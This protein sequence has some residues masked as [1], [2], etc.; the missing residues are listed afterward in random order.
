MKKLKTI[1]IILGVLLAIFVVIG[2]V[3]STVYEDK[4]KSYILQQVNNSIATKVDVG[5]IEFSVFKKFPYASLEFKEITAE[6]VTKKEKKGELFKAQS[7]YLQFNIID[8]L[9]E[10]YIIKKIAIV[11]GMINVNIDKYGNDNYHFWKA[12]K[13]STNNSLALELERLTLKRVNFYVLNEYKKLD[14]DI[15]VVGATLSG[16]FSKEE[17]AL[18]TQANFMI[19]QINDNDEAILKNKNIVLNTILNVN[20]ITNIYQIKKG[21]IALEKL[22]FNLNGNIINKKTGVG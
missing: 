21:E 3:F 6:E 10:N 7:V 11:D 5:A 20:Q 18:N 13:D 17:F 2:V 16:N 14:M 15:E 9:Q 12:S 8:I 19:N 4:V 22:K 1:S